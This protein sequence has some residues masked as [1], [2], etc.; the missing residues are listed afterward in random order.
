M[1]TINWHMVNVLAAIFIGVAGLQ[2]I[3]FLAA[4]KS[5]F[6]TKKEYDRSVESFNKKL[7]DSHGFSIYVSRIEWKEYRQE[8]E[9]KY[10]NMYKDI[11]KKIDKL[12]IS[13][14]NMKGG[15]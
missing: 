11:S 7:Y 10:D 5:I 1:E 8:N 4:A 3:I 13:I 2:G 9:R 6:I 14:L 12:N 15:S